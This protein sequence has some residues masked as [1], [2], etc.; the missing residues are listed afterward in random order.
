MIAPKKGCDHGQCGS[1]T[2]LLDGR[3]VTTC[4]AFAVAARRRRDHH[5]RRARHGRRSAP[6]AAGVPRP[7]RLSVRVLHAGSDLLGGRDAGRARGGLAE[8]RDRRTSGR[9]PSARPTEIRERMS[10]NL[11]RCGAYVNIVAA[12]EQAAAM[13][14]S[15]SSARPSRR[16]RWRWLPAPRRGVPRRRHE[17]RRPH[18]ARD[19]RP[20]P[21][22]RRHPAAVRRR[23]GAADG[24]VRIGAGV[25]NS[26]LA[27][28]PL[29][30]ERYPVLS[31]ALLAGASGQLR[32]LA[33]TA[34]QPAA[35]HALRV[36]PG[37][38]DAVQQARARFR[39][40]GDWRLLPRAGHPRRL[41]ALHRDPPLRHGGGDGGAR[42]RRAGAGTAT[43]RAASPSV[44]C[45]GCPATRPNATPRSPTAS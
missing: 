41:R 39:L 8:P 23:R 28:H 21:A 32:N 15:P 36:L 2:V 16:P 5:R 24:G 43:G 25:R 14:A 12:I 6:D 11:C 29:V 30:R 20:G 35:A 26:D 13:R 38:H 7:R 40:L 9:R 45:T 3:R 34:R 37:S 10:G 4:L 33:T 19:R 18:E 44:S 1:C 22:R 17:P 42:R 31:E 27:A